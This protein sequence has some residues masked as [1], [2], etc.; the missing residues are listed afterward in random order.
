MRDHQAILRSLIIGCI[1]IGGCAG[2]ESRPK[3]RQENAGT[4]PVIAPYQKM[5][6]SPELPQLNGNSGLSDYLEY[7]GLNNPGLKAAFYRWRAALEEIPQAKTL[8]DPVMRYGNY[9][10]Q[11]DMQMAQMAE[12][13]QMFPWFG[14]LEAQAGSAEARADAARAEMEGIRLDLYQRVKKE[15]YEFLYLKEAIDIAVQ[16]AELMRHFEEVARI[17]YATASG[18]HPDLIRAQIE[19]S[20]LEEVLLS[21]R[22]LKQPQTERLN[23]L[24][25]RPEKAELEWPRREEFSKP[26]IDYTRLIERLKAKNPQLAGLD[27]MLEEAR[28]ETLLAR[29]KFYPDWGVGAEWTQ[30]EQSGMNSGRDAIAILFQMNVP[31]WRESYKAAERQAKTKEK[32]IQQQRIDTENSLAAQVASTLY[33][34]EEDRRKI[35]LYEEILP[36]TEELVKASETAY[37]AGTV[38]FLSLIDAQRMLLQYTLDYQRALTDYEQKLAE[39]EMLTGGEIPRLGNQAA[40]ESASEEPNK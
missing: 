39:L 14:K 2:G 29:T 10:R 21:L 37:M 27:S 13:M 23:A 4:S 18:S 28:Q 9:V 16:N 26:E 1:L 6:E 40:A 31:I 34:A 12:V 36:K 15:F 24:L 19:R 11:S 30:F 35:T 33:E 7:A 25:H 38:D 22:E 32:M 20:K 8:P 5:E 3:I 17:K